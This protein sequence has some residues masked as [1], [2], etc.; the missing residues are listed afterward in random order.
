MNIINPSRGGNPFS[1]EQTAEIQRVLGQGKV[2][3][4]PTDTLYGLGADATS[5][6]AVDMLYSLKSRENS[7][8][9]V[10]LASTA[11]LFEMVTDLSKNALELIETFMPGALTV[12]CKSKYE[13]APQLISDNGTVGF[14]VPDHK[15]SCLLPELFGK[16]ITTTSV[17]P[18]GKKPASSKADVEA[19]YDKQ[20]ELM[21]DIGPV[22]QSKGSTVIDLTTSPFKILREGEISR[23]ALQDFL[24]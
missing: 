12:I 15:I 6:V 19:Y 9:S 16:P 20:V 11:Q 17:N 13:F 8:I 24:N 18:A 7:P 14:R 3:V 2:I 22:H 5:S 1:A 23:Q 4:Y 10:L 21:L